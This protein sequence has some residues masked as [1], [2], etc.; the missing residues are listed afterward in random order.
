MEGA[1][2]VRNQVDGQVGRDFTTKFS[3]ATG[4]AT[5]ARSRRTG[6]QGIMAAR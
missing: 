4:N 5:I 2:T 6:P 1:G 3:E